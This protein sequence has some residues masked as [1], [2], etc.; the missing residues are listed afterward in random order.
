[1]KTAELNTQDQRAIDPRA[2]VA[3]RN[4]HLTN[5]RS[6][7]VNPDLSFIGRLRRHAGP[8]LSRCMQCGTCSG[9][10]DLSPDDNPFPRK[11]MAW[12][13]L[14][15]KDRL[16][17]D[18]DVWLCYQCNDCSMRCPCGAKPGEVL[19]AVRQECV[20]HYAIPQFLGRWVNEPHFIP[21]LI[22]IPAAL[23]TLILVLKG[24]IEGALNIAKYD[25]AHIVYSYSSLLPHWLLNSFFG[26]F[27]IV[28]LTLA[29]FACNRFWRAMKQYLP[30]DRIAAPVK[31]VRASIVAAVKSAIMHD[32]F[33]SCTNSRSRLISHMLVVF[34]FVALVLA[35]IWMVTA[36]YN[37]LVRIDFK[38]PLA[39]L[40]PWKMLANAGGL[41]V[42]AGCLL[43]IRDRY[44]NRVKVGP[45]GYFDWLL[46]TTVLIVALTG[47]AAEV[48]HYLRLEPHRHVT[49]YVH[50]VF[51]GTLLFYM[52]YS[53]LSHMFYRTTA[54]VFAERY[55][56]TRSCEAE[57][58]PEP[59]APEPEETDDAP[60]PSA[61]E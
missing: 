41:A 34:G 43:M 35:V 27:A 6:L 19:Q 5:G 7:S 4:A 39:F 26:F 20:R 42:L 50:L 22:G 36:T 59:V 61:E 11:E 31:T 32:K 58:A 29:G 53:K 10:C 38:Y 13:N 18:P 25:P 1:M 12:A 60:E 56:R 17:A 46:I 57:P 21:L 3:S 55:G 44:I 49:Y 47:F 40:N 14:G 30:A 54:M 2:G 28:A 8:T 45:G 37:P 51:V 23:V 16:M 52:P 15:M 48:M 24:P 9:T 33:D